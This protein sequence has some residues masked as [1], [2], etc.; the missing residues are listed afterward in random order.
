MTLQ[1]RQ[2][3]QRAKQ[4]QFLKEQGLI[5]DEAEVKGGAGAASPSFDTSSVTSTNV[6]GHAGSIVSFP[7]TP[8]FR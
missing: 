1:E 6:S 3:L 8:R 5:K 7:G 2:A 4:L